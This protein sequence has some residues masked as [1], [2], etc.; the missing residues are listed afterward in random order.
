MKG[1]ALWSEY[2]GSHSKAFFP[3]IRLS[4]SDGRSFSPSDKSKVSFFGFFSLSF[5]CYLVAFGLRGMVEFSK[6]LRA[7]RC[8]CFLEELEGGILLDLNLFCGRWSL[9]NL[10]LSTRSYSFGLELTPLKLEAKLPL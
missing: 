7:Q 1:L 8:G 4:F 2:L 9:R 10:K 5:P 3:E 6:G